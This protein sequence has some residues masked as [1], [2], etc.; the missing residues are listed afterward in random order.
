MRRL[1]MQAYRVMVYIAKHQDSCGADISRDLNMA[2]GTL[3]PLL[4]KLT[5]DK[6]ITGKWEKGRQF[7]R[8]T[9]KGLREAEQTSEFLNGSG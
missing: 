7:F 9:K 2:S 5:Q 4:R 8:A 1:S 3:Y 6:L